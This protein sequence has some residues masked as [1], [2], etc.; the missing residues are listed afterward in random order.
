M[1]RR[2]V[3]QPRTVV[4]PVFMKIRSTAFLGVPRDF[5][6]LKAKTPYNANLTVW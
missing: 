2:S 5:I 1:L 4:L 6:S 3:R